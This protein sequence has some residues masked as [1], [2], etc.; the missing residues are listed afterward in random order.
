[1]NKTIKKIL[2]C[3]DW[4]NFEIDDFYTVNYH[5]ISIPM[6]LKYGYEQRVNC[7]IYINHKTGEELS[8][9]KTIQNGEINHINFNSN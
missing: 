2:K 6:Y 3:I 1:M 4:K 8:V 9:Y 7:I 5:H